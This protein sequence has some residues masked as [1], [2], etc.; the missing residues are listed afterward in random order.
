MSAPPGK[1][2]TDDEQKEVF[3]RE[4]RKR[5]ERRE[6]FEREG[7]SS[8]WG[9]VGTMGTVGWS[10]ALPTALG[11]LLGRWLDGVLEAGHVFMVFFMLVGLG[12]GCFMAWRTVAEKI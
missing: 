9:V 1:P 12:L 4:V 7:D 11:V 5:R 3:L 10:V 8:F 2:V 6:R